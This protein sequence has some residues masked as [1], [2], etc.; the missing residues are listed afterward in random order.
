MKLT[1]SAVFLVGAAVWLGPASA[2]EQAVTLAAPNMWCPTCP[3]IVQEAIKDVGG[4]KVI[5]ITMDSRTNTAFFEVVY[6]DE[7]TSIEARTAGTDEYGF[8]TSVVEQS[9]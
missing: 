3:Y 6:D 2:A 5:G 7:L 9:N 1:P 4:T 8:P